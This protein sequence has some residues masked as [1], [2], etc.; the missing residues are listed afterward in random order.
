LQPTWA[1][2]HCNLAATLL[3]LGRYDDA[4]ISAREAL[5][6]R[7]DYVEAYENLSGAL[8]ELKQYD[9]AAEALRR[10]L[11]LRPDSAEIHNG[12]AGVLLMQGRFNEALVEV[13]QAL[14]LDFNLAG[15]HANLG[16]TFF[17]M[18]RLAEAE[19]TYNE[20]LQRHPDNAEVH[21]NRSLLWLMQGDFTRGWPEY[22]WRW[23][24]RDA[25]Q[26][27]F[28]A[29]PWDGSPLAGRTILLYA[30]QG[31][32]DTL[33]FIRYASL[34]KRRGGTVIVESQPPLVKF[35]SACPGIDRVV[36]YGDELPPFDVHAALMSLPAIFGTRLESIPNEV[37]YLLVDTELRQ[38]WRDELASQPGFKV[39]IT[40][41]GRQ[42]TNWV[43]YRSIPLQKFAPLAQIPGVKLFSLQKGAGVEQLLTRTFEVTDFGNRLDEQT[44]PFLDSAALMRNLDLVV[45]A[46]TATAHLAGALGV[47]VWV[48][49]PVVPDWR[50]MLDRTDSPWYPTMR[51]FRQTRLGDWESVFAQMADELKML[52]SRP[53]GRQAKSGD[54]SP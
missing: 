48:A 45:T 46:D 4:V 20:T 38:K 29:V 35:L 33:Q 7:P 10:C 53:K 49:L 44:G 17:L 18:G 47:P 5:R 13:H 52:A 43:A 51:L 12:L 24:R 15:A 36:A 2:G 3:N 32:G 37:P 16:T 39:G 28:Y 27:N 8:K 50:W 34:V 14:L 6:L 30:E 26:R 1:E 9:E 42:E 22:E 41:Q 31:M 54:A 11:Q 19:A 25:V 40:W 21:W 23:R